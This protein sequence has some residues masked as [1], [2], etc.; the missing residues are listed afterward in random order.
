MYRDEHGNTMS[1]VT[2]SP[3][4]HPFISDLGI[5]PDGNVWACRGGS[6]IKTWD[7]V[8]PEGELLSSIIV[9]HSSYKLYP[10]IVMNY[11]E[12]YSYDMI[13]DDFQRIYKMTLR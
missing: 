13:P 11:G 6:G 1:Q 4:Y 12:I 9:L 8:S 5:G 10:R 2:N 3:D 7:V